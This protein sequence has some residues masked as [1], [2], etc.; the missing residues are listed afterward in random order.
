[1]T[2]T[3]VSVVVGDGV[4]VPLIAHP[5]AAARVTAAVSD[6]SLPLTMDSVPPSIP[7]SDSSG[8][9]SLGIPTCGA[10]SRQP[11]RQARPVGA[12]ELGD[13]RP[14]LTVLFERPITT[15]MTYCRG[16][17]AG[18]GTTFAVTN[19]GSVRPSVI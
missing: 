7:Y 18:V 13:V 6:H 3:S 17:S 14:Q 9:L 2:M 1:M 16:A 19:F 10:V 15:T 8:T 4:G 12:P 11:W 5:V